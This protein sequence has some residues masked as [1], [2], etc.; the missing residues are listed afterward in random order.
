MCIESSI[1]SKCKQNIE[2]KKNDDAWNGRKDK[3]ESGMMS[4]SIKMRDRYIVIQQQ[5]EEETQRIRREAS[6]LFWRDTSQRRY[7]SYSR[8]LFSSN[9]ATGRSNSNSNRR[10]YSMWCYG[11]HYILWIRLLNSIGKMCGIKYHRRWADFDKK[12]IVMLSHFMLIDWTF[13]MVAVSTVS[14]LFQ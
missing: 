6:L 8:C 1:S 9:N 10:C 7:L 13:T 5:R 4:E 11:S 2:A 3:W 14:I 12:L